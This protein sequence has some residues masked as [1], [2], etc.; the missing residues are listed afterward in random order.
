MEIKTKEDLINLLEVLYHSY[1]QFYK[2][3]GGKGTPGESPE[4]NAGDTAER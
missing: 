2:A 3:Y 4:N 1:Q